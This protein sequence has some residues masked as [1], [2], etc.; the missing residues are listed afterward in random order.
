MGTYIMVT[1]KPECISR[2]N[3]D[4]AAITG[5]PAGWLV[6]SRP[7]IEAEITWIRSNGDNEREEALCNQVQTV[8]DWNRVFPLKK[9]G[10]GQIKI[11]GISY[12]SDIRQKTQ[13]VITWLV[14][15]R[16]LFEK[17]EGL[18]EAGAHG[19]VT[20]P[21]TQNAPAAAPPVA[22]QSREYR[23]VWRISIPDVDAKDARKAAHEALRYLEESGRAEG[24]FEVIT[25]EGHQEIVDFGEECEECEEEGPT[26]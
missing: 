7:T 22:R 21:D 10:V 2:V 12:D 3:A 20:I 11:S 6:W 5:N 14:N 8:E 4:Y 23:V 17:I 13:D 19:F 18:D 24:V 25:P 9:E 1:A 26:P 16:D 15:H